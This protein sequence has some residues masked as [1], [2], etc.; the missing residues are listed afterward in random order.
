VTALR[1]VWALVRKEWHHYF[2]SPI[3]YVLLTMWSF[4]EGIFFS[5][6]FYSYLD[7]SFATAQQAEFGM[8]MSLNDMVF[9]PVFQNMSVVALFMTPMLTM[10][11][12]AEE[13]RQGTMELLATSPLTDLQIVLGKFFA[14]VGLFAAMI[15]VGFANLLLVWA[16]AP[17]PPEWRPIASG[18]FAVFLLGCALIALGLFV[19][20]LTKNQIVA[21][22]VT[23]SLTLGIWVLGW[24]DSPTAGPFMK[25]VSYFGI[26]NHLEDLLRGVIDLKDIVFYL[27]FITFGLVLAH[28]SVESQRWRA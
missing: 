7:R 25:F 15:L 16:Y 19:S 5:A 22:V 6:T 26:T 4:L 3:A 2:T 23:F 21:A 9:N 10:R 18:L 8:K 14:A 17:T 13:K 27:S 28:Q 12:F 11:L 20:T 24:F 1:N